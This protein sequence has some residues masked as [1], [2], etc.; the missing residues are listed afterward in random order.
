MK[1][2]ISVII[3]IY[4]VENYLDK[5]LKSVL[6]QTYKNLEIILVDDGSPDRCGIISDNYAAL[7]D[8][9]IVIHK[10]NGGLSDARNAGIEIATGEYITFIDSDDYVSRDYVETMYQNIIETQSDISIVDVNLVY[11]D[12]Y[13]NI[14]KESSDDERVL[15]YS[16]VDAIKKTLSV[17]LRQ[18]AWGKLYKAYL[19]NEI[20]FPKGKLY[21]DLAVVYQL[22]SISK[23]VVY[24]TKK[25]YQYLI[26]NNSIM[27]SDFSMKQLVEIEIIDEVMDYVESKYPEF[28][29]ETNGRRIYSY[30]VTL[31]RIMYSENSKNYIKEK[32]E[33]HKKI[34]M[35]RHGLLFTRKINMNLKVKLITYF[36]S[37]KLYFWIQKQV[38]KKNPECIQ[39]KGK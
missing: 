21:E 7:D 6:C 8:R 13:Y 29:I 37:E 33:I 20:R 32:R 31:K 36:I 16:N 1:E 24:S 35:H 25:L 4:K 27:Q 30:L 3:P 26:R 11:E 34:K 28:Y 38:D 22:L 9:V 39:N 19:F 12:D 15:T 5:C 23:R 17:S 10:E 14:N 2:L 18:S